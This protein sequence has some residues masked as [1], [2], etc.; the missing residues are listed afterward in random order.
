MKM[1]KIHWP[2]ITKRTKKDY[3]KRSF[4]KRK[5]KKAAIWTRAI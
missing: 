4:Q 2:N 1:P 5:R 3:K